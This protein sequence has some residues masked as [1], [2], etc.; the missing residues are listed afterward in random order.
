MCIV[1]PQAKNV[2][3]TQIYVAGL[4]NNQQL[5]V[6]S[7]NVTIDK[8]AAMILPFPNYTNK[9]ELIDLSDY[10]NIFEDLSM[11]FPILKSN[12]FTLNSFSQSKTR[13][14]EVFTSGSYLVSIAKTIDDLKRVNTD[15]FK[16]EG[17]IHKLFMNNYNTHYGFM[18]CM[19]KD[20]SQFHPLAYIHDRFD[21]KKLF[22]PTLHY[23][24]HIETKPDWA[25]TIYIQNN[26]DKLNVSFGISEQT[27]S[28]NKQPIDTTKII[29]SLDKPVSL[30][31]LSIDSS[32]YGNHDICINVY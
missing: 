14:L 16:I 1:V 25:H 3:N 12:S 17:D 32:Y 4:A 27:V 5:T 10:K 20:S 11:Y 28:L 30:T 6:Y 18:I 7:N 9:I 15:V 26:K 13:S 29:K 8:P 23:H 2:S 31:K 19:L 22:I 24:G 21:T